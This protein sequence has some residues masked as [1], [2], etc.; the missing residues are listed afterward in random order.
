MPSLGKTLIIAGLALTALGLLF[1][2]S[3]KLPFQL[4]KLP[5]DFE[6]RGKNSVVY[7]PLGTCLVL[8]VLGSLLMWV[9]GR[10][11]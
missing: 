5:G 4:G 7:L 2:L 11:R 3:E 10:L 8:S 1:L 9:V 6:F